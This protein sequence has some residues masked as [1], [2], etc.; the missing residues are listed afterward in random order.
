MVNKSIQIIVRWCYPN[1]TTAQR[2]W[3][4]VSRCIGNSICTCTFDQMTIDNANKNR[5]STKIIENFSRKEYCC[6]IKV[7]QT[8]NSLV[9]WHK[10]H[11]SDFLCLKNL[12]HFVE[13]FIHYISIC[14]NI[15]H[16]IFP[17]WIFQSFNNS[18]CEFQTTWGNNPTLERA[19][20]T[21]RQKADFVPKKPLE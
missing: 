17:N 8:T 4:R 3:K 19:R 9:V 10:R 20:S 15:S 13:L 2:S 12:S 11:L 5:I 21:N 16:G 7:A 6:T 18:V 14:L 1:T